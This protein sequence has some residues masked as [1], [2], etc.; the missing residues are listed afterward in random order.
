MVGPQTLITVFKSLSIHWCHVI[1]LCCVYRKCKLMKETVFYL[2]GHGIDSIHRSCA[3]ISISP[4]LDCN[5][6]LIL[7]P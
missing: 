1:L 5:E 3:Q 6:C 2:T 7:Q 4:Q